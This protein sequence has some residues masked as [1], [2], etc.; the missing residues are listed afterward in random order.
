LDKFN[1]FEI[2]SFTSF[3]SGR[4][5]WN[6]DTLVKNYFNFPINFH[7]QQ[8]SRDFVIAENI[9]LLLP[10]HWLI[11]ESNRLL[12]LGYV[13]PLS[14]YEISTLNEIIIK[15]SKILRSFPFNL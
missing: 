11:N 14:Q 7:T 12:Q 8:W 2:V 4:I 13:E 6:D 10:L 1:F 3:N 15:S 9:I 5:N